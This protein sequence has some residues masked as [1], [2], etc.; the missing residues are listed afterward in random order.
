LFGQQRRGLGRGLEHR[1]A[2]LPHAEPADGV[3]VEVE[4]RE[5]RGGALSELAVKP[6]LRD[7]EAELAGRAGQVALALG[8]RRRAAHRLLE[9]GARDARRRAD[10]ETHRDVRAEQLLDA[11]GELRREAL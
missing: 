7:R 1:L 10:V 2:V 3:A 5:I 11:R 8:P 6:S 9:L 4:R